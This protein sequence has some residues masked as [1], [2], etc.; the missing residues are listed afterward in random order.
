MIRLVEPQVGEPEIRA[1]AR[2]VR[3]RHLAAG[4]ETAAFEREFARFLGVAA[5]RTVA[6]ANGTAALLA[7]WSLLGLRR[8]DEVLTTPFTFAATANSVLLS[9]A[10]PRFADI[11]PATFGLSP[12]AAR[13]ALDRG[14]RRVKAV[15][16]VHLYGHPAPLEG[17]L[18]LCRR[19]G[20]PLLE[21]CAQAQGALYGG[22]P[23]GT[24]GLA[25]AFS[26]YATKNMACGE[27]GM[28]VVRSARDAARV[29]AFG[30]HGR[31]PRG[32][33]TLGGNLRLNDLASA[34]GRR[35][36]A[37]LSAGN[38][39]RRRNAALYGRLLS[40]VRGLVLPLEW[41]GCRHVYH[42]YTVQISGRDRLARELARRGVEARAFYPRPLT[43][44]PLYLSLGYGR[45]EFPEAER[46]A[47]RCLSI[48]V[49]PGL[50]DRQVERVASALRRAAE[51]L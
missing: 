23:V 25:A 8:G 44:E 30:N 34:V 48:P 51:T 50:T 39:R 6:V 13:R 38:A 15:L 47:A 35:Q 10:R 11:D 33:E 45:L 31:G 36:L 20:L 5:D 41:P 12:E 4:P 32:H 9:G 43:Q 37:R 22:R 49:H 7:A 2:V 28:V 29:R 24:F 26:F 21:D 46:A 17:L 3:S 18:D 27:G 19:K 40:G 42:Q 1:L 14:G 16:A